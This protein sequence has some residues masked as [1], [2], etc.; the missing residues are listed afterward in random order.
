MSNIY[1]WDKLTF[2]KLRFSRKE[3][4][5]KSTSFEE[6]KGARYI[7]ENVY[8]GIIVFS[9][10]SSTKPC[11]TFLFNLFCSRDKR[12][13]LEFLRKWGW[14]H[15]HDKR[16]PKYH[17]QKVK[18]QKTETQFSRW[19]STDNI[20]IDIFLSLENPWTFLLS[21][22]KTCKSIFNT[23]SELPQNLTEK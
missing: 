3:N 16:F 20:D 12:L 5:K 15:G 9:C 2:S 14:F 22:E 8:S 6:Q 1:Y 13:L 18:F 4:L 23:N 11:L 17:G 7:R 21:K 10:L 19:K